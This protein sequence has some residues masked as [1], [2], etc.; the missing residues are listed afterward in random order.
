[1]PSPRKARVRAYAEGAAA[2][3]AAVPIK[4]AAGA[5][6]LVRYLMVRFRSDSRGRRPWRLIRWVIYLRYE[7]AVWLPAA[8]HFPLSLGLLFFTRA[9][10]DLISGGQ[11]VP[12]ARPG[13]DPC[14]VGV[15]HEIS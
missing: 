10:A 9:S 5:V 11:K 6:T 7:R 4:A 2:S 3:V 15:A 14:R 8:H 12:S 13:A 1:M